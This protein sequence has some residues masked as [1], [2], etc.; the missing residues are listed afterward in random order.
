LLDFVKSEYSGWKALLTCY[1][2]SKSGGKILLVVSGEL[3]CCE[4]HFRWKVAA[5]ECS[6]LAL[7]GKK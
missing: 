5:V 7:L 3:I 6:W 1:A 2:S 4:S